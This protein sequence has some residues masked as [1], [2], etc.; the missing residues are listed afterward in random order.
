MTEAQN[1]AIG[2]ILSDFKKDHAM[3]RL[4][5]GDVGSGKTAVA[6]TTAYAI[7]T[8][9]QRDKNLAI[10]QIAYMAPTEI[11]AKQ[12]FE[13]FIEYFTHLGINIGLITGKE[14][15]KFP[16][17]VNP[18]SWTKIS[19]AQLLKWVANGEIPIL[20]GTHALISKSVKFKH[21]GLFN[22]RRTTPLRHIAKAKI[23]T[24]KKV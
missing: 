20:I 5:E 22:Y 17:K 11:L 7:I 9:D 2:T 10:L 15:R 13:S 19:R 3:A 21:L 14:C 16:S 12:H 1:K 6:A 18:K 23:N 4:L 24:E 8:S